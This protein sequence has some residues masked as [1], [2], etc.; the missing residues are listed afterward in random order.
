MF[1]LV[2]SEQI[3]EDAF[4]RSEYGIAATDCETGVE[5]GQIVGWLHQSSAEDS[6]GLIRY[7]APV[8]K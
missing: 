4:V 5:K 3:P 8:A 6:T 1:S 2:G 7:P